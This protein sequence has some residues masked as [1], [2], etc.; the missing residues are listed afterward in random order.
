[1]LQLKKYNFAWIITGE[2]YLLVYLGDLG[3][4]SPIPEQHDKKA[5]PYSSD[6]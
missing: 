3:I 6:T 1:M 2:I 4:S 5:K